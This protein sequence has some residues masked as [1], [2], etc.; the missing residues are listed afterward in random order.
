MD[1]F[2]DRVRLRRKET[3][4]QV[5]A[6]DWLRFSAAAASELRPDSAEGEQRP[7]LI[8]R[9]PNHVLFAGRRIYQSARMTAAQTVPWVGL[10][11]D[12]SH[13]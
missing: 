4:D 10:G 8:E 3:V 13:C 6:R 7:V 1:R 2:D 9:E 5:R 11:T 12:A